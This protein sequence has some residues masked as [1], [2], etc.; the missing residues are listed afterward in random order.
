ML[1]FI[2][3]I[4]A[5][6]LLVTPIFRLVMA[7]GANASGGGS[8]TVSINPFEQMAGGFGDE[9]PGRRQV[10]AKVIE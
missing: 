2:V 4:L 10:E 6:L 8:T 3:S 7:V 5:L 9:S 1:L